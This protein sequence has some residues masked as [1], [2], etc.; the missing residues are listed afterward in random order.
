MRKSYKYR[1]YPNT[2]Q[3]EALVYQ[4]REAADLYNCALE[5]RIGAWS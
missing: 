3:S 4:L 1:V 5:E 2:Q